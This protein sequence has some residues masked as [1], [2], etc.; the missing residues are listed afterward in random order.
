MIYS[1]IDLHKTNIDYTHYKVVKRFY[2]KIKRRSGRSVV[3]AVVDKE[4]A[5]GVW[6]ILTKKQV[7]GIPTAVGTR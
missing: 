4:L 2:R 5:K 1:D 3:R 6:H 7:R